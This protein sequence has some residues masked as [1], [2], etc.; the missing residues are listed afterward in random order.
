MCTANICRSPM[1][2]VLTRHRL[3]TRSEITV[4]SA[5][6]EALAGHIM[7]LSSTRALL[8]R[9]I[10]PEAFRARQLQPDWVARADLTLTASERQRDRLL[11][12]TPEASAR[13]FTLR[14][15]G[16][17]LKEA[18][19]S[20]V[21]DVPTLVAVANNQRRVALPPVPGIDL[22]DPVGGD[23]RAFRECL[24]RID[25]VVTPLASALSAAPG[26]S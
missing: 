20:A 6:V 18:G 9:G 2:E 22:A 8:E 21:L 12:R 7:H 17:L 10:G 24:D 4:E 11:E 19:A 1:M 3:G 26:S 23:I 25:E 5:G 13:L 16:W 15:F 14:E